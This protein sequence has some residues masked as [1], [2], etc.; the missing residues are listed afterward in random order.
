MKTILPFLVFLLF[1]NIV[2]GQTTAIPDPAFEQHLIYHGYD[3]GVPDG[4]VLTANINT[5]TSLTV[6]NQSFVGAQIIND[7]TGIEDFTS[8]TYLDCAENLLTN[9]NLTQNTALTELYCYSNNLSNLDL[10]QNTALTK[11]YCGGNLLSIL[12]VTQNTSLTFLNCAS[13]QL[14]NL[15]LTQNPDL[16]FLSCGSNQLTNLNLTQNI[17]LIYLFCYYNNLNTLDLTS[18]T[19]LIY[20]RCY[21]NQLTNLDLTQSVAL[22]ELEC[23]YNQ[24]SSLDLTQNIA[25]IDLLCQNN[26]LNNLDLTQNSALTDLYCSF[27]ELS[28]LDLTQNTILKY[29]QCHENQLTCLNLKNGNNISIAGIYTY[30]NPNLT[31]IEVDDALWSNSNWVTGPIWYNFDAFTSFSTNCGNPC[32]VG[33]N[34]V[35]Q[36]FTNI[37]VYPNPTTSNIS[38]DLGEIKTNLKATLLNGMGQVI[39]TK[40]YN[41]TDFIN[42]NIE[43]PQGIYFLTLET[44][45]GEIKTIKVLKQ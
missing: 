43:S 18:N 30:S 23:Y 40:E 41:S 33:I 22:T 2:V 5:I 31:C 14:T 36:N 28:S 39:F 19:A 9:L 11:L 38:I 13:S 6:N 16:I 3:S 32:T 34:N 7:L 21:N 12:N 4:T 15:D 25:L 37:S 20:L 42:L 26:Q 10:T 1:S 27:N 29:L 8:L 17:A 24:L 35:E 45:L 44:S